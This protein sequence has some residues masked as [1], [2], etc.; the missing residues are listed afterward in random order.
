MKLLATT[1]RARHLLILAPAL[2]AIAL[3]AA[4]CGS[5]SSGSDELVPG[6]ADTTDSSTGSTTGSTTDLTVVV[7]DGTGETTTWSLTCDPAGGNHP[8]AEA[9]CAALTENAAS[10][11]P[12]TPDDQMCTQLYGGSQTATVTGTWQGEAVEASFSRTDGCE[13]ARWNALVPLLPKA[14]GAGA[15]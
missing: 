15:Q 12:P 4:G 11:L 2:C 13:I 10:A 3:F 7:D 1:R 14:T 6:D 9:A 8:K 5:G